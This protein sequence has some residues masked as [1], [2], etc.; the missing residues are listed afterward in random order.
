MYKFKSIDIDQY[1]NIFKIL[2]YN[3]D[4]Q[5]RYKCFDSEKSEVS[6]RYQNS[7]LILNI[8]TWGVCS[9]MYVWGLVC[10]NFCVYIH[11]ESQVSLKCPISQAIHLFQYRFCHQYLRL[12]YQVQLVGQQG[13]NLSPRIIN[14]CHSPNFLGGYQGSI[15][16][17]SQQV[18]YQT[19]YLLSP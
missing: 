9:C 8:L 7:L 12:V 2:I 10:M 13:G 16:G 14:T 15:S 3:Q 17:L 5:Y 19:S 11:V 1:K 6:T 4:I 18:R